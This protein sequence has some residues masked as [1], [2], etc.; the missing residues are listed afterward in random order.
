MTFRVGQ[1]V[2]C[3]DVKNRNGNWLGLVK[4]AIYTISGLGKCRDGSPGVSIEED[5]DPTWIFFADRF[6]PIVSR[7]TDISI[8][9]AMLN[10]SKQGIDA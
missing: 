5:S 6:R 3:V 4:G 7:T 8:F 2:V 10:P 9:R 1:K